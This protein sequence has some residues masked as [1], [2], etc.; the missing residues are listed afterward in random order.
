MFKNLNT[1]KIVGITIFISIFLSSCISKGDIVEIK[2]K[3]TDIK[4][5]LEEDEGETTETNY[6]IIL[7]SIMTNPEEVKKFLLEGGKIEDKRPE[8]IKELDWSNKLIP[9]K[10]EESKTHIYYVNYMGRDNENQITVD[11]RLKE[12]VFNEIFLDAGIEFKATEQLDASSDQ[13]SDTRGNKFEI[14]GEKFVSTSRLEMEGRIEGLSSHEE[15]WEESSKT[16]TNR[17]RITPVSRFEM[18]K[19][20]SIS[21]EDYNKSIENI[22]Q[23]RETDESDKNNFE[24]LADSSNGLI[25]QLYNL[26]DNDLDK[27]WSHFTGTYRKLRENKG[28]LSRLAYFKKLNSDKSSL[29]DSKKSLLD[30]YNKLLERIDSVLGEFNIGDISA[31]RHQTELEKIQIQLQLEQDKNKEFL[32]SINSLTRQ[33]EFMNDELKRITYENQN[34]RNQENNQSQKVSNLNQRNRTSNL[35]KVNK[36][37]DEFRK[38]IGNNNIIKEALNFSSNLVTEGNNKYYIVQ[39]GDTLAQIAAYY[40][41]Y[42]FFDMS[43]LFGNINES[44]FKNP[45]NRDKAGS[46]LLILLPKRTD[47]EN[48]IL[49][50]IKSSKSNIIEE[51]NNK[52]YITKNDNSSLTQIAL[53]YFTHAFQDML[54]LIVN[55]NGISRP[56]SIVPGDKI[57]LPEIR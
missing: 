5:I 13:K 36:A 27:N 25:R 15:Y 10:D 12:K 29:D 1:L 28:D 55:K 44:N 57:R 16:L 47:E 38:I 14:A 33:I 2:Q 50:A 37:E 21:F 46:N 32:N 31:Q 22:K 7:T 18:W 23:K 56:N 11:F 3:V 48:I 4:E 6:K 20:F 30:E 26:K 43:K 19:K 52:Y 45:K 41:S 42:V 9:I 35:E 54:K 17:K 8:W 51:N 40:F 39:E 24:R 34:N 53:Y 49:D